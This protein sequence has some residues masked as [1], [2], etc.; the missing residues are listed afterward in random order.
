MGTTGVSDRAATDAHAVG[1]DAAGPDRAIER[2]ITTGAGLGIAAVAVYATF[3]FVPWGPAP[4]VVVASLFGIFLGIGCVGLRMFVTVHQR[5]VAADVAAALGVC[6]G[7]MVMLMLIVQLAIRNPEL[8]TTVDP[9]VRDALVT[10][11]DRVHFGIDVTWDV[12]IAGATLL[13]ALSAW[14]H[15]RLGRVVALSGALVALALLATNLATFPTPPASSGSVDVGP[16]IGLWYVAVSIRV[17]R[18]M[19]WVRTRLAARAGTGR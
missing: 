8:A 9:V 16:L 19:P 11:L 18:S 10:G 1:G 15:P 4:G 14:S 13:F 5:S 2:W 3:F 12:L 7:A 17:L 6:A